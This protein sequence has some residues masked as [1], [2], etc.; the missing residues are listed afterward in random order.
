MAKTLASAWVSVS[1]S[2]FSDFAKKAQA[3][4]KGALKG[5]DASVAVTADTKPAVGSI[6]DLKIRLDE[7]SRNVATARVDVDDKDSDAKLAAM[8]VKLDRLSARV[9]SPNITLEGAARVEAEL[10]AVDA[11]FDRLN[12]KT[13]TTGS[14]LLDLASSTGGMGALIGAGI[15][16]SPVLVTSAVGLAGFAAAAYSIGKPIL[17]AAQATGG[18]AANMGT[19]DP[20]QQ[21]VATG[22]LTLGTNYGTFVKQ[23]QP[24]VFSAFNSGLGIA[25]TLL[26]DAAPVAVAAGKGLDNVVADL[27]AD[28]K[29]SQWTDFFTFMAQTAQPDIQLLGGAFL[30]LINDLPQLLENLQP[31]AVTMLE[32]VTDA[33]R[34]IG[35]TDQLATSEGNLASSVNQSSGFLGTLKDAVKN[36][37]DQL[38]PGVKSLPVLKALLDKLGGSAGNAADASKKLATQTGA[39]KA[40]MV[41]A[42]PSTTNLATDISILGSDTA[43]AANQATALSDAWLILVGNFAGRET[44]IVNAK[45]AVQSFAD[46][47]KNSGAGSLA[48]QSAFESAVTAI[49]QIT[50]ADIASHAPASTVYNDIVAQYDALKAKGPLN[51]SEKEQLDGIRKFL[52]ITATSTEGW[53]GATKTAA[54]VIEANLLPQLLSMHV[55]TPKTRTDVDN[56]T[57]SIINTGDKSTATHDARQKLIQDLENAGINAH[58]A[59]ALVNG[60][61]TQIDQLR[62]KTVHVGMT[63][64]GSFSL[65]E[66]NAATGKQQQAASGMLVPG[67]G[68][69]DTVPALLKPGELVIPTH[70]VNA[71]VADNMRGRI[72]GFASGGVVSGNLTPGFIS[73]M[74]TD[75]QGQMTAAMVAAMRAALRAAE[76]AA[77][78][79][80]VEA[81][82]PLTPGHGNIPANAYAIAAFL[83]QHGFTR[84][85]TAGILGNIEQESE[86]DGRAA[87]RRAGA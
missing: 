67:T 56:L 81:V 59:T 79:A 32:I 24:E 16:L 69:R 64:T 7:L 66:I 44:A 1:P 8:G 84:I 37:F 46:A 3:G 52:D 11:S 10:L 61:Q 58:D 25:N 40:A 78:A 57:N 41:A 38:E 42:Q 87:T 62:G 4:I 85:A 43:T 75:F 33:S 49:G 26:G 77:K 72:P 23:L 5:T 80:A 6:D 70:L 82:G 22:L 29:T 48:A 54:G 60:L 83:E 76:S 35:I 28:L 50:A 73:G 71:G 86:P 14:S 12:D 45:Q 34:L 47:I 19:L 51:L 36:A 17:A 18:L 68:I 55:L 13:E 39:A 30:A 21:Q 27:S 31:V 65:S 2:G 20:Q 53:T 15:A 9:V 63:G 74:Y